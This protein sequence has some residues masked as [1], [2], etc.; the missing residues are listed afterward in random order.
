M[1]I[2][3]LK[4]YIIQIET[5]KRNAFICPT[6][7]GENSDI[8]IRYESYLRY[9]VVLPNEISGGVDEFYE[10]SSEETEEA[11]ISIT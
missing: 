1:N 8:E 5:E 9:T 10:E 3:N 11:I 7:G 4:I 2:F 6:D